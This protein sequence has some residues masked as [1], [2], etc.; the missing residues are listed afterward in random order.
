M[1]ADADAETAVSDDE[2]EFD[3]QVE[4]E[5]FVAT[6]FPLNSPKYGFANQ[7]SGILQRLQVLL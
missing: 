4:Q 1:L 6:E 5:P 2:A 3:W 7:Q